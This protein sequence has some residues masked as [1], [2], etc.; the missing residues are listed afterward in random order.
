MLA[1]RVEQPTGTPDTPD[2]RMLPAYDNYL[3]GYRTREVS[4]PA[5]RRV[6]VWPGGGIIRPTVIA[7]GLVVGTWTRG[8][9]S[10]SVQVDTFE[11]GPPEI[12]EGIEREKEAVA[13]F[14]RAA[15]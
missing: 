3:V 5:L 11:P 10:R 7:D 2:V 4:V 12:E 8:S 15:E 13:R 9:G 6:G 1:D 14:L